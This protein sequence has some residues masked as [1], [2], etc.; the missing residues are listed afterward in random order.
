M[1]ADE[2]KSAQAS[3]AAGRPSDAAATG[4][5]A[6]APPVQ[7]VGRRWR[8]IIALGVL[9][10]LVVGGYAS[11]RVLHPPEAANELVLQGNIDVR[12]VNLAFKVDGR[13]DS[14]EVDEGD[15][16]KAGQVVA[17]LDKR[18]FDDDLR[19]AIARRDNAAANLARL[20]HG[21]RP[22]EIADARARTFGARATLERARL[23]FERAESLVGR[24]AVSQQNLDQTRAALRESEAQLKSAQ[25]SQALA[26]IG[27][28]QEDIDAGRATLAAENAAVIQSERR[29]TDSEFIAPN[30]GVILT[31]AREKGAI[32]APG[33]TVFTL[34]LA[35]PVWVRTYVDEPD[36]GKIFPGMKAG[37]TT[38]SH[39]G[40]VYAGRIGFISPTAEFTPKNVETRAL[41][42]DLV[43]RLRVI[44]DNPDHGLRQGMPVTVTFDL[45][46]EGEP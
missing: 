33:E 43:Y 3:S 16:V 22:E 11:Y 24:G 18:Y 7:D 36:L 6:A 15:E 25:E 38:D 41:R 1:S 9:V 40:K 29:L 4:R 5:P 17:T 30:D 27:P 39:P 10:V 12:Q 35:T 34:T 28:R 23:D 46:Q 37:V 32:V 2:A 8:T 45:K 21:S 42:T 31:R 19:A 13:I 20:E 26:E 14:L 44:V